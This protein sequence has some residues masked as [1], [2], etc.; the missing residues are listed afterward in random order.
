[1]ENHYSRE[2]YVYLTKLIERA[3][4]FP[5]MVGSVKKYIELNPKLNKD[6]RKLVS[7]G[8]KSLIDKKR[9][10]WSLLN[11]MKEKNSKNQ[12]ECDNIEEIK[13]KIKNELNKA[14][15]E[16]HTLVDN[17]YITII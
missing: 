7:V 6:E 3:E 10:A 4:R 11:S 16:L 5:E 2:E 15:E 9:S 17:Y 12:S 1:M 8:Y 14:C 13:N